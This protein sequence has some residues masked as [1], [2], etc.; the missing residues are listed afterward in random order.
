MA[1]EVTIDLSEYRMPKERQR[2]VTGFCK[3]CD[4]ELDDKRKSYCAD[5]QP[6]PAERTRRKPK[7]K[8]TQNVEKGMTSIVAKLLFMFTLA[9]AWSQLRARSIPDPN[10]DVAEEM[11]MTDEEAEIIGRPLTR[12]FLA[13]SPGRNIAPTLVANEDLIDAAFAGWDWYKRQV[14][15]IEKLTAEHSV[16]P[17]TPLPIQQPRQKGRRRRGTH[18][19]PAARDRQQDQGPSIGRVVDG[20]YVGWAPGSAGDYADPG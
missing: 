6:A 1:D 11:A 9:L 8:V 17:V 16:T 15:I 5:H 3:V 20:Q 18:T 13:T 12:M 4:A 7:G 10:G 14:T 19:E 2:A